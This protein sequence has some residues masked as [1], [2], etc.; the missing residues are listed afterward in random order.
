MLRV[1]RPVDVLRF[2]R[3]VV[4]EYVFDVDDPAKL[5]FS[6]VERR[7]AADVGASSRSTAAST[8]MLQGSPFARRIDVTT[9]S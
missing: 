3:L 7:A 9:G 4:L 8:G 1:L 5:A 6:V 2:T